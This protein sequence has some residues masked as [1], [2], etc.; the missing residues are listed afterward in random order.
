ME[1]DILGLVIRQGHAAVDLMIANRKN[2]A[3]SRFRVV[4]DTRVQLHISIVPYILGQLQILLQ[5]QGWGT[6][7]SK[8][9]LE[10]D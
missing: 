3:T 1:N 6:G 7:G 5:G 8:R 4:T 2:N 10:A 9:P